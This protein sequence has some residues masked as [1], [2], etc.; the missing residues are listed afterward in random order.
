MSRARIPLLLAL[1]AVAVLLALT[2]SG[3]AGAR[4]AGSKTKPFTA[5]VS[6]KQTSQGHQDGSSQVD[7]K[8]KGTFSAKLSSSAADVAALIAL[9]TGVPLKQMAQGGTYDI[10]FN[11]SGHGIRS[12]LIVAKFKAHGLGTSCAKFTEMPGTYKPGM[13]FGPMNGSVTAVAGTQSAARW[14][15]KAT[16]KETS[17]SGISTEQFGGKGSILEASTGSPRPLTKACKRVAAI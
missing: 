8:G 11:I 17:V 6:Y 12:G 16:F 1:P 4:Q 7:I 13:S 3:A 2:T 5:R 9:A 10:E 15:I 14:R